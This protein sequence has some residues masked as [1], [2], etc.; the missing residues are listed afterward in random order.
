MKLA[1]LTWHRAARIHPLDLPSR[2]SDLVRQVHDESDF[3]LDIGPTHHDLAVVYAT[4]CEALTEDVA[5]RV[6]ELAV[7]T[8]R[9]TPASNTYTELHGRQPNTIYIYCGSPTKINVRMRILLQVCGLVDRQDFSDPWVP[10]SSSFASIYFAVLAD[11]MGQHNDM[12]PV[13]DDPWV[14]RAAGAVEHLTGL[15]TGTTS[16]PSKDVHNA[17]LHLALQAVLEPKGLA[18]IPVG[19]ILKFRRRH[20]AELAAFHQHIDSLGE[21]LA[22][23]AEVENLTV[24]QAHLQALYD[25]RTKPMLDGLRRALRGLGIESTAGALGLRIDLNA[26]TGTLLGG[27]AAASGQLALAGAAVAVGVLP[28]VASRVRA[29]EQHKASPVAYLLAANRE[30]TGPLL[31]RAM[32]VR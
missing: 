6:R 22:R 19:K 15:L 23:V 13:T 14:H 10:V 16:P 12:S 24:A 5:T 21:E 30:L 27:V 26:A 18:D 9:C 8:P 1:L 25:S 2:D 32:R 17:Y 4:F 29:R 31:L 11:V 20:G 3:I 28:Y 7:H